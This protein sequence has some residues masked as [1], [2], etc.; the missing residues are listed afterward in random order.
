[1]GL[2]IASVV[3]MRDLGGGEVEIGHNPVVVQARSDVVADV[4]V[5]LWSGRVFPSGEGWRQPGVQ[6]LKLDVREV[7][8]GWLLPELSELAEDHRSNPGGG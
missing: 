3:A 7:E 8:G 1:M 6:L 5:T 2:Y 4:M